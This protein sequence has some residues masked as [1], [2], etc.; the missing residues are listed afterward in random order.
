[1]S[2]FHRWAFCAAILL[3]ALT[4]AIWAIRQRSRDQPAVSLQVAGTSSRVKPFAYSAPPQ[5]YPHSVIL[6][7]VRTAAELK[8]ALA[9][10][11]AARVHY[12]GFDVEKAHP[13]FAGTE[14]LQYVSYRRKNQ[15][16]WTAKPLRIH[17]GELLLADGDNLARARCGNRLSLTPRQ[18]TETHPPENLEDSDQLSFVFGPYPPADFSLP[19][20]TD[21]ALTSDQALLPDSTQNPKISIANTGSLGQSPAAKIVPGAGGFSAPNLVPLSTF[22]PGLVASAGTAAGASGAR[23]GAG[24]AGL[25][26]AAAT[27]AQDVPTPE[28]SS[29]ALV[30]AGALLVVLAVLGR[31]FL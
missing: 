29:S 7:G 2:Y 15:I 22:G 1:M 18:P 12:A 3:L 10:D 20:F 19:D 13:V 4:A 9:K 5:L 6:G 14:M 21:A 30:A 17:K 23:A 8:L 28:P 25:G 16:Y 26:T 24:A 31:R 11:E 27:G